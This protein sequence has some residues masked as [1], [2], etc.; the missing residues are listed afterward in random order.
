MSD[1]APRSRRVDLSN[2]CA[3]AY[4]RRATLSRTRARAAVAVLRREALAR[5]PSDLSA[6]CRADQCRTGHR[7]LSGATIAGDA[8]VCAR[9]ACSAVHTA[10]AARPAR[11]GAI[12]RGLGRMALVSGVACLAALA[13]AV[14]GE[15]HADG[16][17]GGWSRS[18]QHLSRGCAARWASFTKRDHTSRFEASAQ[19][20]Q[21]SVLD[22]DSW[23]A[24][25][26]WR[27][28]AM[29]DLYGNATAKRAF[30]RADLF[31]R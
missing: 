14:E 16:E 12:G 10:P 17:S 6:L 21:C 24:Q 29:L 9:V 8:V 26:N 1:L 3:R 31:C 4:A 7:R 28:D 5:A 25:S 2:P 15:S 23:K 11:C 19:E 20:T 22:C 13:T 27:K 30:C 18:R